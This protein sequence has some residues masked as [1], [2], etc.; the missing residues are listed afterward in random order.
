VLAPRRAAQ[1]IEAADGEIP[2]VADPCDAPGPVSRDGDGTQAPDAGEASRET[3][4]RVS[5]DRGAPSDSSS[6]HPG[7]GLLEGRYRIV[8]RLGEGGMGVVYE[9]RDALL[10]IPVA[11]KTLSRLDADGIYRIKNEF[12]SV[13]SVVHENLVPLY[14]L[15]AERG[16]WFFTMGLIGGGSFTEHVREDADLGFSHTVEAR[17]DDAAPDETVRGAVVASAPMRGAFRERTLRDALRQLASGVA[18]IHG[19]GL[20]HRDLKPSNV[21]VTRPGRVVILDFGLVSGRGDDA[22]GQTLLD[23]S[24]SGTPAYMAPEQA[25]GERATAASDWYAV[26]VM[27]FEALTGELPFRGNLYDILHAKRSADAPAP[28]A[29]AAGIPS[30]LDALCAALLRR[31][32][33][34]RPSGP[35]ILAAL[36][37]TVP[38]AILSASFEPSLASSPA[39]SRPEADPRATFVGRAAKL[40]TL[41]E[42]LHATDQ[43]APIV[44]LVAGPSGMGKTALVE[45]FLEQTRATE[46]LIVLSSRCYEREAMPYKA[47]DGIIDAL[48]R[49]LRRAGAAQASRL[50]PRNVQALVRLFPVLERVEAIAGARQR[51]ALPADPQE[52]RR[53]GVGALKEILSRMAEARRVIVA[54]DDLQWGDLDSVKL[55]RELCAPPDPPAVV[56]LGTYRDDEPSPFLTELFNPERG[57]RDVEVRT[58]KL[59]P[60]GEAE[61]AELVRASGASDV[62]VAEVQR[63][64]HGSPYFVSELVRYAASQSGS[65]DLRLDAALQARLSTVS[66]ETS[67]PRERF[68]LSHSFASWPSR[69]AAWLPSA[70]PPRALTRIPSSASR[71][72]VPPRSRRSSSLNPSPPRSCFAAASRSS[73]GSSTRPSRT[74]PAPTRCTNP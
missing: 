70:L 60:L 62:D 6:L 55:L 37:A 57:L 8:R 72:T 27:L 52:L 64:A 20:L 53:R 44:A 12:R 13:A 71:P 9:A 65:A 5:G 15:H 38:S 46:D 68:R 48:S 66:T 43:G 61:V 29:R 32:P 21:L 49:H 35:E 74:M 40:R 7:D 14:E 26:G 19:A 23:A 56:V 41:G 28:S 63:E 36:G 51:T 47:F 33:E 69:P 42:C 18:V 4:V 59:E 11:L 73:R 67:S 39:A 17:A 54:I 2:A 45:R 22:V 24:V 50:V 31:R 58:L 25:G 34:E 30:D 3:G 10:G 16:R 1:P